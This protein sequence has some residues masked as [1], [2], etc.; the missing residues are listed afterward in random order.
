MNKVFGKKTDFALVREDASRV[1]ISYGYQEADSDN[2]TWYEVYLY[3]K[4]VSQITL[5]SVKAAILGDINSKTDGKILS[6][7]VWNGISVWLSA[8]NQRNF[9][10][11]QRV[12]E[13]AAA[14][15]IKFKLGEDEE[16]NPVYHT[17]ET[18]EDLNDFYLKAF[19]YIN[20]CLTE[21][22]AEKDAIDW[23][24]YEALFPVIETSSQ[25]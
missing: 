3:K 11:A 1:I 15:P 9:S 13:T 21:G 10:E 23:T 6:G 17:F 12:A 22:W 19:A 16:G 20:Q 8:E 14:L 7:F 4:Q 2:A 18:A 5:D 25:E 24:P